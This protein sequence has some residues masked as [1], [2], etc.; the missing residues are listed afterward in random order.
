M[1]REGF[2]VSE[3]TLP[4]LLS[5]YRDT[6]MRFGIQERAWRVGVSKDNG[7]LMRSLV[8]T[9]VELDDEIIARYD[10]P[11]PDPDESA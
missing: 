8:Q 6:A 5:A 10:T 2:Q 7:D 3:R 1:R 4:E 9:L 11:A